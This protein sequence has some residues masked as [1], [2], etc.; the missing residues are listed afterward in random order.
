M[1]AGAS[2]GV[3]TLLRESSPADL[4]EGIAAFPSAGRKKLSA[5]LGTDAVADNSGTAAVAE[6]PSTAVAVENPSA[7]AMAGN[8]GA[9]AAKEPLIVAGKDTIIVEIGTAG[10]FLCHGSQKAFE[11]VEQVLLVLDSRDIFNIFEAKLKKLS[12]RTKNKIIVF[13]LLPSIT[14]SPTALIGAEI[15]LLN[16][17]CAID[18]QPDG[19]VD[20]I[21]A[22]R[23][24]DYLHHGDAILVAMVEQ[25][26]KVYPAEEAVNMLAFISPTEK[27]VTIDI[28]NRWEFMRP[29]A[30][31]D[32]E[33]L[34]ALKELL[35][36]R[37][38]DLSPLVQPA[39]RRFCF[40]F[41]SPDQRHAASIFLQLCKVTEVTHTEPND[42]PEDFPL[43]VPRAWSDPENMPDVGLFAGEYFCSPEDCDEE[44]ESEDGM[45][46]L[47]SR[48]DNNVYCKRAWVHWVCGCG[49]DESEIQEA[50]QNTFI[51]LLKNGS[52]LPLLDS[53]AAGVAATAPRAVFG[54]RQH[55]V[56]IAFSESTAAKYSTETGCPVFACIGGVQ[57]VKN[58]QS[59]S[60]EQLE[61]LTDKQKAFLEIRRME[62]KQEPGWEVDDETEEEGAARKAYRE[63]AG[64]TTDEM[65]DDMIMSE[66][67]MALSK[68]N[69]VPLQGAL[70]NVF[71]PCSYPVLIVGPEDLKAL[72]TDSSY[73]DSKAPAA[74]FIRIYKELLPDRVLSV[75]LVDKDYESFASNNWLLPAMC[76]FRDECDA[77]IFVT[78]KEVTQAA[79]F[80]TKA[81]HPDEHVGRALTC[82]QVLFPMLHF[83]TMATAL[84]KKLENMDILVPALTVGGAGISG[85]PADRFLCDIERK[86]GFIM[87]D[88]EWK[89]MTE[90]ALLAADGFAGASVIQPGKL[91]R[92]LL[93]AIS[94]NAR[95]KMPLELQEDDCD[96]EDGEYCGEKV[97]RRASPKW[98]VIFGEDYGA[99]EDKELVEAE[100]KLNDLVAEYQQYFDLPPERMGD[101]EDEEEEDFDL[102]PERYGDEEEEDE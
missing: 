63:A 76:R 14:S 36:G 102:P 17:A 59:I 61:V 78:D 51:P 18:A 2:I 28:S 7:A 8:L 42:D 83:F 31:S 71:G 87:C 90:R 41:S 101:G 64:I 92:K 57:D 88:K 56:F 33:M 26:K 44:E 99:L 62:E 6:S 15:G 24:D 68:V 3:S 60:V 43:G 21:C 48:F 29:R 98:S 25:G 12:E 40:D 23:I 27:L 73:K 1:G 49:R 66:I 30:K 39:Q 84:G 11:E 85:I 69:G 10:A 52:A 81:R 70:G 32:D 97:E 100:D 89:P 86:P 47:S 67:R 75:I 58:I 96:S 45:G 82:Q 55:P 16:L 5:A 4:K 80:F 79:A 54:S 53:P 95:N 77:V 65:D 38:L 37:D 91:I 34:A 72:A 93:I 94:E 50:I 74:A 35:M 13:V 22:V 46:N 20:G 9:A 19:S